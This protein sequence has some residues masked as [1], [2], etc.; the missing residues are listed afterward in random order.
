M[1]NLLIFAA[2]LWPISARAEQIVLT[3]RGDGIV[4]ARVP[5]ADPRPADD[6]APAQSRIVYLNRGGITLSPGG[7]DSRTNQSSLIQERIVIP[8]WSASEALWA[9]TLSCVRVMFARFD[10]QITDIDP[11]NTPHIEAVFGGKPEMFDLGANV[12]GVSP[13]STTCR[14]VESSIVF[15]FTDVI[16]QDPQVACEVMAQEIAHSYGLDH[17]MLAADPMSYLSYAG[18][19]SF[20]DQLAECGETTARPCGLQGLPSCRERQ[21]SVALLR[22][23]AGVPGAGD[24]VAPTVKIVSPA[25]GATVQPGFE[26]VATISDDVGVRLA[27][28]SLDGVMVGALATEPWRF[29]TS[30]DLPPGSYRLTVNA[31]DGA[32]DTS[33]TVEI[34]LGDEASTVPGCAATGG[35][36]GVVLAALLAMTLRG[37]R[38][39]RSRD[40]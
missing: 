1:R 15:T 17:E 16:R 14:T 2:I 3:P 23:R 31:T 32:N 18:K 5:V 28:V 22:A 11:G 35:R 25:D 30:G 34:R 7:N 37:R 40:V 21:N 4:L 8:P 26:V 13:F 27:T 19:R 9:D 29:D 12:A 33:A 36:P 20:Q 24:H 10:L 39:R 38:R 6:A